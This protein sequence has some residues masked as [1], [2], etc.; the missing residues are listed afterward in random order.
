MPKINEEPKE[1][2]FTETEV[3]D[4]ISDALAHIDIDDDYQI[5]FID[6]YIA[7]LY[8]SLNIQG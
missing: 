2:T 1:R 5:Y 6:D 7:N 8:T 3:R 4:A